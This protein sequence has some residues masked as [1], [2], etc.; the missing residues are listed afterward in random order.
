MGFIFRVN[1]VTGSG[2]ATSVASAEC[3]G[4]DLHAKTKLMFAAPFLVLVLPLPMLLKAH[5][6]HRATVFGVP[7]RYAY[8]AAVL[9]GWWLVHPAV[10]AHCVVTLMTLSVAGK[11]YALADLSIEASDPAYQ[12]TRSLATMMLCT[13]V[14]AVPLYIFGQL[15]RWRRALRADE[16]GEMPEGPRIWLFYF[17]GS[18]AAAQ[19]YWEAVVFAVR[20][21]MALLTSLSSTFVGHGMLQLI[22]VALLGVRAR[23]L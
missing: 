9:V 15:H 6:R 7:R 11:E 2:D 5:L 13:F 1:A 21:A 8:K 20:T 19:F 12:A 23:D 4:L 3:F 18:Y 16:Q 10:L 14:P 22:D 17:Y